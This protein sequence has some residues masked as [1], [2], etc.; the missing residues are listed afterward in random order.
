MQRKQGVGH[1]SMGGYIFYYC[2]FTLGSFFFADQYSIW[3]VLWKKKYDP[4]S[5]LNYGYFAF[6]SFI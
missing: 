4:N 5:Q 1:L 3:I 2:M 6:V